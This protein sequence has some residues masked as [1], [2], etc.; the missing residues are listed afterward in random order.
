MGHRVHNMPICTHTVH[1]RWGL[2]P[3]RKGH[4]CMRLRYKYIG[5][6]FAMDEVA[7]RMYAAL[8]IDRLH[9]EALMETVIRCSATVQA[10][11]LN[12][13]CYKAPS[14]LQTTRA[15]ALALTPIHRVVFRPPPCPL[16]RL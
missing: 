3:Q 14:I 9:G 4:A 16:S 10:A 1:V 12:V 5:G 2:D 15:L 6:D 8:Y 13:I 7:Q 11:W